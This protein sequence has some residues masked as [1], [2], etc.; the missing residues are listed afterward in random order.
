MLYMF[1]RFVAL[2]NLPSIQRLMS[3]TDAF[4]LRFLAIAYDIWNYWCTTCDSFNCRACI[5][6]G[7][8]GHRHTMSWTR[9]VKTSPKAQFVLGNYKIC[10]KC[11]Q[12]YFHHL[13]QGFEC[14]I[15]RENHCCLS[16]IVKNIRPK[17]PFCG[18]KPSM[19]DFLLLRG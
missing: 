17:H 12:Q 10:D 7:R 2:S 19:F 6:A 13:F 9:V 14:T 16:C 1:K 18:G 4:Q 11:G 15:C 3:D 5:D 8:A